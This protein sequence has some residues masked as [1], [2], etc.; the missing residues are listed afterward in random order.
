MKPFDFLL[1][2]DSDDNPLQDSWGIP[3]E[4]TMTFAGGTTNDPGDHDGT[5]NPATLFTVTGS[6][7]F[8]LMAVCT[9]II[10][11]ASA[12]IE[13]GTTK[14]TAN[15]IAQTTATNIDADEIWHDASPDNNVETAATIVEN[16]LG[17]GQ[18]IIQTI[19]TAN[20]TSGVILYIVRYLPFSK[21]GKII[22]A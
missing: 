11:G 21:D 2:T 16:V 17:G 7:R 15:I 13:V 1:P 5:G 22:P 4:K 8:R 10:A 3:V 6:V 12:T 19:A 14:S 20:I 18:D 9:T